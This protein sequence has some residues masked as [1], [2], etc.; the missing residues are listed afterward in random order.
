[1]MRYLG[2]LMFLSGCQGLWA[3]PS[4]SLQPLRVQVLAPAELAR[5]NRTIVSEA[6]AIPKA[7]HVVA[8][9][10]S[11]VAAVEGTPASSGEVAVVGAGLRLEAAD[12]TM[13]TGTTLTD[14]NG[15]ARLPRLATSAPVVAA[16]YFVS[17]GRAYRLTTLIPADAADQVIALD[18]INTMIEAA[19][20]DA[21]HRHPEAT[22]LGWSSLSHVR[23]ICLKHGV[24]CNANDLAY[25]PGAAGAGQNLQASWEKEVAEKVGDA[26][27]RDELQAFT[28]RLVVL[29][30]P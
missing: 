29:G 13:L 25:T 24:T 28:H 1:M 16:A 3:I 30:T 4:G 26:V 5:G 23:A 6:S 9:R 2:L 7:N 15:A 10:R 27:E 19:A 14:A 22:L 17:G 20:A 8:A 12:G 11:H 18:P 21:A